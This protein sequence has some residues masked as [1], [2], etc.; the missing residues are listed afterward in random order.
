[1]LHALRK[2]PLLVSLIII[3]LGLCITC[4]IFVYYGFH[5]GIKP[6]KG[7]PTDAANCGDGDFGGV[8][9]ILFG[10]PIMLFGLMTL[11]AAVLLKWRRPNFNRTKFLNIV[12]ILLGALIMC[13]FTI[14]WL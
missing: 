3:A 1:M 7:L 13:L 2:K 14:G 6:C 10:V 4:G 8:I 9:F 11:A 5:L 12:Y